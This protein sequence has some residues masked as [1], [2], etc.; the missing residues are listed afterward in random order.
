MIE[1]RSFNS[2]SLNMSLIG[3]GIISEFFLD[4][5]DKAIRNS[6]GQNDSIEDLASPTATTPGEVKHTDEPER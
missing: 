4:H 6:G 5:Y 2:K 3:P 1:V